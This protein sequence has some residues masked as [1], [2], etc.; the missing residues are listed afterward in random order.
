MNRKI[1]K[2]FTSKKSAENFAKK[3][4]G[5]VKD[6]TIYPKRKSN[7]KVIYTKAGVQAYYNK[8]NSDTGVWSP[9]TGHDFG[10]PNEYWQ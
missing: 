6:Y 7:Y 9:E 3:V 2:R 10:Y 1:G 5:I 8:N 4:G